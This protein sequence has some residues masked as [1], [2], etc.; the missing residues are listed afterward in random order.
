MSN[1]EMLGT[2]PSILG[3]RHGDS[4]TVHIFMEWHEQEEEFHDVI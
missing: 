4:Y 3:A 1:L 2:S